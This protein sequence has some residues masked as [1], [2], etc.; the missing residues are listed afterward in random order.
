[1]DNKNLEIKQRVVTNFTPLAALALGLFA[2]SSFLVL[3]D[4]LLGISQLLSLLTLIF[5]FPY[6]IKKSYFTT[7]GNL[8]AFIGMLTIMPWLITGGYA[9]T[10]FMWSIVYIVGVYFITVKRHTII[11]L[12]L[13]LVVAVILVILSHFGYFKIAYTKPEL[14]NFLVMY[15]FTFAFINQFNYVR[16]FYLKLSVEKEK[17]LSQK[18]TALEAAN[19]ELA[20]FAYVASHDLKEPLLT[21]SGFVSVLENKYA[22][23]GDFET[24]QYYVYIS[25]AIK[26]MQLLIADLLD[27]SRIGSNNS[28]KAYTE[29]E[30]HDLIK[31]V[32]NDLSISI[33]KFNADIHFSKMPK[34]WANAIELQMVFQNLISNAIKFRKKDVKVEISIP[35]TENNDDYIFAIK[36][37][38]IGIEEKYQDKIFTIFQRLHSTEEYAGSG[39]GLSICKKIITLHRGKI[40][41]ASKL[42]EGST[43]YFSIPKLNGV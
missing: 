6:L 21:I 20:Q 27:L 33:L 37:N 42:N 43:F 29:V 28:I 19:V 11:W 32:L 3:H 4:Y 24:D 14:L 23:K 35:V 30:T 18:N 31:N 22:K 2:L 12:S 10:G 38:G 9:N 5:V 34:V 39:I 40:W 8:L 13:Y 15:I 17:E 26:R 1:M 41:V 16:E 25:D 7:A 36:D